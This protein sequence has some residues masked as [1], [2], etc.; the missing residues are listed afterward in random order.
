MKFNDL[1]LGKKLFIVLGIPIY[2][3]L[4]LFFITHYF[5]IT[6]FFL[7]LYAIFFMSLIR[8]EQIWLRLTKIG[9]LTFIIY[10]IMFINVSHLPNQ[11]ARRLPGGRQALLE[12]NNS[13]VLEFKQ[14]FYE[15]HLIKYGKNYEDLLETTNDELEL[16]LKRVDYYIRTQRVDYEYDISAPYYYYDH[17]PTIDEIFA[18]DIDGDGYLQD[19]CDGI[20][21]LT[22]SLLLNMGYNAWVVEVEFHYHTM[23]FRESVDPKTKEGFEQGIKLY[24]SRNKPPYLLFNQEEMIIPPTH[25]ILMSFIDVYTGSSMYESYLQR[26]IDGDYFNLNFSVMLIILYILM[27]IIA[28]LI[29]LFTKAGK[30]SQNPTEKEKNMGFL[31]KAFVLSFIL[32]GGI[33][34]LYFLAKMSLGFLGT[35]V[36]AITL[37]VGFRI[38]DHLTNQDANNKNMVSENGG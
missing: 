25:S 4:I 18:S 6:A 7:I 24:N 19:D 17:F 29:N 30:E 12:P 10:L 35:T 26:F 23:V 1:S 37:I 21:F 13:H 16:K 14:D 31:K 3:F 36:L 5:Q 33:L 15:W 38:S 9:F 2:A 27:V 32:Y 11:F 28:G 34:V 22:V 20:T 8:K